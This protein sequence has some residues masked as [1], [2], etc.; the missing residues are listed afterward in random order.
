MGKEAVKDVALFDNP[1]LFNQAMLDDIAAA[2]ESVF[3]EMY[4]FGHDGNGERFRDLLVKK[5]AEG[6]QVKLLLDSWGTPPNPAFFGE[7]SKNGGEVRYFKKIRFFLD[8]FTKNHRR[9][10]R[11]LLIIDDR[12]TYIGSANIT[13]YS[14][15]WRELVLKL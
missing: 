4:K 10:H 2:K 1:V 3:L 9:N 7:I 13:S 6:L 15:N 12:I 11:K 14:M 5:C 8:F